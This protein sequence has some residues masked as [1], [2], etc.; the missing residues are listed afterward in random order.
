MMLPQRA[1]LLRKGEKQVIKWT[2]EGT[3]K[4][5]EAEYSV[6]CGHTLVVGDMKVSRKVRSIMLRI[7][8][9]PRIGIIRP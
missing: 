6:T 9:A 3:V 7:K 2:A 8:V 4:C 1:L 5:R